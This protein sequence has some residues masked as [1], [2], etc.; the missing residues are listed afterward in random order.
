MGDV[1]R[2]YEVA[3]T[4]FNRR[5]AAK[6]Q[7][8]AVQAAYEVD[9]AP[10]YSVL[11]AQRRLADSD[12]RFFAALVEY[13]LAVKNVHFE[14]GSLLD[15]NQV[16]LSEGPWPD[17]A[18]R[19]AQRYQRPMRKGMNL[20]YLITKPTVITQGEV[21]QGT[22]APPPPGIDKPLPPTPPQQPEELPGKPQGQPLPGLKDNPTTGIW[23]NPPAAPAISQLPPLHNGSA[24]VAGFNG[25][26]PMA[27][28]QPP[29]MSNQPP[30][31]PSCA[32]NL[33][34]SNSPAPSVW[35]VVQPEGFDRT[36]FNSPR[37]NDPN[38]MPGYNPVQQAS[39]AV[40]LPPV[41]IVTQPVPPGPFS[42]PQSN[43]IVRPGP[44]A[45]LPLVSPGPFSG[46]QSNTIVRPGL[47]T[48]T[49]TFGP[50][51]P[52][53]NNQLRMNAPQTATGPSPS[54]PVFAPP[55]SAVA[56]RVG[57][58]SSAGSNPNPY[59]EL[60]TN[61]SPAASSSTGTP[62]AT[63]PTFAPPAS[64]SASGSDYF[65]PRR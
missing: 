56:P 20:N 46:P 30:Q 1:Q 51:A 34:R 39:A 8:A 21:P 5:V 44:V 26:P 11:D 58:N 3:Q 59:Q 62:S 10:L 36:S 32:P 24:T 60:T 40:P 53:A 28:P 16:F 49:P 42:G 64:S 57:S 18:G 54:T 65:E 63:R 31:S 27:A 50:P 12:S 35:P 17:K 14:K 13:A 48:E 19:D 45:E 41:N 9:K 52:A 2:A 6:Q 61:W 22:L 47:A 33:S 7:V 37:G 25:Q 23:Q 43:T 38:M 29:L 4:D 55:P 15:Y